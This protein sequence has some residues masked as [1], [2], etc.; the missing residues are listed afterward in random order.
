MSNV[1]TLESLRDELETKYGSFIFQAGKQK[2]ELPPLLRLPETEREQAFNLIRSSEEVQESGD[3][4]EMQGLFEDLI[5]VL[6]RDGKG[7]ALL[8][9]VEHDLLSMQ[10]LIQKWT[11]KTQPGEA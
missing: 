3:L 4:K 2:F 9:L 11:E 8:D 5:R 10:V 1:F 6:T 7:D